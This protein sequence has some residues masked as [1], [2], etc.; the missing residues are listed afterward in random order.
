LIL[1]TH[2]KAGG[3]KMKSLFKALMVFVLTPVLSNAQ[4]DQTSTTSPPLS[5]PLIREGTLAMKLA[6]GFKVGAPANEAEAE[7][8]LNAAGIAP[9]N[10]WIADYAVTPDIVVELQTAVSQAAESGKIAAEKDAALKTFQ[11]VITEFGLSVKAGT[12][13]QGAGETSA[14]NYPDSTVINNYYYNEG[15]PVVTYYA[16]PP[17][18]AYL[19][20]WVPYPFWWWNFWFP[21][22]FVLSDFDV[23]VHGHGHGEFISN[24][25]RDFRTGRI[26]RIDPAN[27]FHGRT[28]RNRESTGWASPSARR[29]AEAIFNRNRDFTTGRGNRTSVS[30]QGNR[31]APSNLGRTRTGG[32]RS[33]FRGYGART[34]TGTRSSAFEHSTNSRFERSASER[35]FQ[36]RSGAGYISGGGR[37]SGQGFRGTGGG[38]GFHGGGRR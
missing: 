21:G 5:Q 24:H 10:G 16:P 29:G 25:F 4:V 28:F 7:S 1:L 20:V 30:P 19:Y 8:M 38:I 36:S 18:F 11:D 34:Y 22:F 15:P 6:E 17:D 32:A 3:A 37:S 27:R 31:L 14:P 12:S 33:E 13:G 26:S 35:G 9:R 2:G 23:R